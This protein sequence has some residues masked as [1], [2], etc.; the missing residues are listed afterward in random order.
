MSLIHNLL[1]LNHADRQLRALRTRL[2]GAE[3]VLTKAKRSELDA[4][5][6]EREFKVQAMQVRATAANIEAESGSIHDRIERHRAELNKSTN[7]KQYESLLAE[8]KML[9]DKRSELDSQALQYLE[10]ADQLE[11]QASSASGDLQKRH[12]ASA[13]AESELAERRA[14]IG[15]RLT[16]LELARAQAAAAIPATELARFNK[17]ADATDGEAMAEVVTLDV[18]RREYACG[19]CHMELP[20]ATFAAVATHPESVFSCA[21]CRRILYLAN[22]PESAEATV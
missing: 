21:T 15:E 13:R 12:D 7:M 20:S 9:Q 8:M 6:R 22:E 3:L 10:R 14:D 19:E 5:T 2:D 18:K 17:L 16:E 11:S 4:A 1:T